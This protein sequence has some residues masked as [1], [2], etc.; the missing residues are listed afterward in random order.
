MLTVPLL[1]VAIFLSVLFLII[2][3][4]I[5]NDFNENDFNNRLQ[6]L[7]EFMKRTNAESPLPDKIS[8]VSEVDGH[9]F[10]VTTFDTNTLTV[11]GIT[12]HDDR[13]EIFNFLNQTFLSPNID[14]ADDSRVREHPDGKVDAFQLRGDDGWF[15]VKCPYGKRFDPVTNKCV[16]ISFCEGKPPGNYGLTEQMIDSLILNHMV[17]KNTNASNGNNDDADVAAIHP[18][19][20]L[21]CFE[22]GSHAILECPPSHLFDKATSECILRND[23]ESRPDGFVLNT[24]PE[25]L[26]INE[27]LVCENNEPTTA[28][29]PKNKIFDRRLLSCVDADPCSIHGE[30]YT[31]ITN[32]IGPSQFFRCTSATES[33]LITC[34]NRI[35]TDNEY[36][37]AGDVECTLFDNG[38]GTQIKSFSDE[39]VEF[40]TG[41]LICDNYN[42]VSN[43]DCDTT[44]IIDDRVF[45]EK[46]KVNLHVPRQMYDNTIGDCVSFRMNLFTMKSPYFAIESLP[47]DLNVNI[48]TSMIGETNKLNLLLSTT[49]DGITVSDRIDDVVT[50]A[51]NFDAVALN[52]LDGTELQC[53]GEKIY[54]VFDGRRL[55]VCNDENELEETIN[56]NEEQFI[57]S[58]SVTI[59]HDVDYGSACASRLDKIT[60]FV[61]FDHFTARILA[62]IL[63]NDVCGEILNDIH[64]SYTTISTKYTTINDQYNYKNVKPQFYINGNDTNIRKNGIT[65]FEKD[66]DND[67]INTNNFVPDIFVTKKNDHDKIDD[68]NEYDDKI[69]NNDIVKPIFDPFEYFDTIEPNF[70]PF[71]SNIDDN[72]HTKKLSINVEDN[73]IVNKQV[74]NQ[75]PFG[76]QTDARDHDR[77]PSP[78][79]IQVPNPPTTPPIPSP[80][81]PQLILDQK[82]I[83][84]SCFYALPTFKYSM[85]DIKNDHI[86][87]SFNRLKNNVNIHPD[88]V[89]ASGLS[90]V[91]NSYAYLGDGFGCQCLYRP[92]DGGIVIDRIDDG[93]VFTNL[94]SQSNDGFKYNKWIYKNNDMFLACPPDY[95]D[96]ENFQ[97]NIPDNVL[98]YIENLQI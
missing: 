51:R 71:V 63:H 49:A 39:T 31:F 10:T 17:I 58:I 42:I 70:N 18:T 35:F 38:T 64:A 48:N 47:N 96:N 91:I 37:C 44:N 65:I 54:D 20:Y 12:T 89:K 77:T 6:V 29:C 14:D 23:C 90:N 87:E 33:E 15:D 25:N 4:I 72:N 85:C 16:S 59:G 95:L 81:P 94:E 1:L 92:D 66:N 43:I 22:G 45:N 28:Q 36:R 86:I 78:P 68:K 56:L 93:Q 2:Y 80:E 13:I 82:L 76:R 75:Q 60:N 84:F 30:G 98:Y 24:F 8:Y 26:N 88:C 53:F 21:R 69:E 73:V 11:L 19:M 40:N 83:E 34:I 97:C 32:D 41:V 9:I 52:P 46:F 62:D 5:Y 27:Y 67:K 61:N 55:N 79:P 3:L 7:L 57:R 74:L 50:Y